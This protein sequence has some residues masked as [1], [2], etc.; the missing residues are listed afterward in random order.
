MVAVLYT[1]IVKEPE[2]YLLTPHKSKRICS[3]LVKGEEAGN[4][5][6]LLLYD[7]YCIKHE[8]LRNVHAATLSNTL[9]YKYCKVFVCAKV[10]YLDDFHIVPFD[11]TYFCYR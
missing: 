5:P 3:Y 4:N 1:R 8:V 9:V 7:R 2:S 10:F 11:R 6:L